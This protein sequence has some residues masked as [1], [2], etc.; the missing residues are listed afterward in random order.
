V[1]KKCTCIVPFF[2]EGKRLGYVLGKLVK[3]KTLAQIIAVDDGSTDNSYKIAQQFLPHITLLKNQKNLG[4]TQAIKTALK[5]IK[6][7]YILL[8]DADLKFINYQ[9]I[10]NIVET[11]LKKNDL[12]MLV[13]ARNK[14]YWLNKLCRISIAFSG[15]RILTKNDLEKIIKQ[16]K[17]EGYCLEPAINQYML[18][19]EKTLKFIEFNAG[20]TYAYE[21]FGL[22]KGIVKEYKMFTNF[23]KF[24]G[25]FNF[26]KQLFK[27][28]SIMSQL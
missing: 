1:I 17:P 16:Q 22:G 2:N 27:F 6:S 11:F 25:F 23:I 9:E 8:F 7:F 5:K 20:Q 10:N 19:K 4:K 21:K 24:L 12:D 28:T 15:E 18:N 26:I 13:L 14:E 3:V